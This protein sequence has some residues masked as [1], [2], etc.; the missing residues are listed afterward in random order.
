M[1]ESKAYEL[2]ISGVAESI[3]CTIADG[4]VTYLPMDDEVWFEVIYNKYGI[5]LDRC[6]IVAGR[7]EDADDRVDQYAATCVVDKMRYER[8]VLMSVEDDGVLVSEAYD[9]MLRDVYANGR[10]LGDCAKHTKNLTIV[11][12]S[13]S[14]YACT[15][16]DANG[17]LAETVT[18][19]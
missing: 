6:G 5:E 3:T 7:V 16:L 11:Y 14:G 15:L 19:K 18:V 13:E 8:L 10:V 1:I 12:V 2:L 17:T 4:Y 9:V